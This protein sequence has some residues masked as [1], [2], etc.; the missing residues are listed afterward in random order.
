MLN[1]DSP[2]FIAAFDPLTGNK[3]WTFI[4]KYANQSSL[5]VTA[6]D[7]IFGGRPGW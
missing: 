7:L 5:L 2:P 6:G 3:Q 1:P 4:T